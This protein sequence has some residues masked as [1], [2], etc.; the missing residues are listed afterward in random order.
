MPT[1]IEPGLVE[2]GVGD[3]KEAGNSYSIAVISIKKISP[4]LVGVHP[5][6]ANP[7]S[8]TPRDS[9][10]ALNPEIRKEYGSSLLR[11]SVW[12]FESSLEAESTKTTGTLLLAYPSFS[13]ELKHR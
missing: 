5:G 7:I 4:S 2:T 6:N 9:D 12:V 11:A 1:G 8:N 3:G 13:L 10:I